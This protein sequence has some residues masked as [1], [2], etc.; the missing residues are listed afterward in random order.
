MTAQ[1]IDLHSTPEPWWIFA[2]GR[3]YQKDGRRKKEKKAEAMVDLRGRCEREGRRKQNPMNCIKR[4]NIQHFKVKKKKKITA[5]KPTCTA[6]KPTCTAGK[7]PA[8]IMG[9]LLN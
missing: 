9:I 5:G 7:P 2:E 1:I 6:G 4:P 8:I 3:L